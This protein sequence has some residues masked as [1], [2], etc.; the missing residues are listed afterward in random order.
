MLTLFAAVFSIYQLDSNFYLLII[1]VLIDTLLLHFSEM[2]L[3]PLPVLSSS[4]VAACDN[5]M[6]WEGHSLATV[7]SDDYQ[8][9]CSK[10]YKST[11][12]TLTLLSRA[13]LCDKIMECPQCQLFSDD[14]PPCDSSNSLF[15]R[16]QSHSGYTYIVLQQQSLASVSSDEN[17]Y[18][19]STLCLTY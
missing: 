12:A 8:T 11:V 17:Q 16:L 1:F 4:P 13:E 3:C 2:I 10:D 6:G 9:L 5:T 18:D 14:Y 7:S 19:F 15:K